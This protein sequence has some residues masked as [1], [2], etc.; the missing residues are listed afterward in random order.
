MGLVRLQGEVDCLYIRP[1]DVTAIAWGTM[2]K[3]CTA[4]HVRGES[5]PWHV[6]GTP[7]E[8]HAALFPPEA[9]FVTKEQNERIR[10]AMAHLHAQAPIGQL[11]P[12]FDIP[13]T[14]FPA[15]DVSATAISDSFIIPKADL[16]EALDPR[17]YDAEW[18]EHSP[19][20]VRAMYHA[21]GLV[22]ARLGVALDMTQEKKR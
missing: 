1:E 14:P 6:K 4:V 18:R 11:D 12:G 21:L 17:T 8:V 15:A 19:Q 7:D 2:D 3:D 10:E 9:I 5:E 13:W 16:T 20:C 22:R